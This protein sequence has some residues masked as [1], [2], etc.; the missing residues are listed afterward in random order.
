MCQLILKIRA[1]KGDLPL[2]AKLKYEKMKIFLE[3]CLI[4]RSTMTPKTTSRPRQRRK[5]AKHDAK[6][7]ENDPKPVQIGLKIARKRSETCTGSTFL[8]GRIAS[9]C[10]EFFG[11]I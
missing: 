6:T 11:L 3:F 1:V 4:D 7:F 10:R 2:R 9:D 8:D 5:D